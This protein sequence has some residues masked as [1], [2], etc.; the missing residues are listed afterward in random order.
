MLDQFTTPNFRLI[1]SDSHPVILSIAEYEIIRP[2]SINTDKNWSKG[3]GYETAKKG[4]AIRAFIKAN[5]EC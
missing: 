3:L 4:E 5:K 2:R 1:L